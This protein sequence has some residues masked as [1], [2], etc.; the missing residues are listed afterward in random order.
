[1]K[2]NS[3]EEWF[4]PESKRLG[5]RKEGLIVELDRTPLSRHLIKKYDIKRKSTLNYHK[6]TQ[7]PQVCVPLELCDNK[8]YILSCLELTVQWMEL[9]LKTEAHRRSVTTQD[10]YIRNLVNYLLSTCQERD[11]ILSRLIKMGLS[12]S[13]R[14]DKIAKATE[15]D[16]INA[17]HQDASN[18]SIFK[19]LA[20]S[21]RLIEIMI[22]KN[23]S[24]LL[25]AS[26]IQ[27]DKQLVYKLMIECLK[28]PV[29][30]GEISGSKFSIPALGDELIKELIEER[31]KNIECMS[32][33][34]YTLLKR[35]SST[36]DL[37]LAKKAVA[38]NP[39][40]YSSLNEELK[41][42][43]EIL[44][45]LSNDSSCLTILG[46]YR[47]CLTKEEIMKYWGKGPVHKRHVYLYRN[48]LEFLKWL[49][50][51]HPDCIMFHPVDSSKNP[52]GVDELLDRGI[53]ISL[54]P[55][56][57]ESLLD[58]PK[59]S[60]ST[61]ERV[62][63]MALE[64]R[65]SLLNCL[66]PSRLKF[67][68]LFLT[69]LGKIKK[70]RMR[71]N[72]ESPIL[73][74]FMKALE[75]MSPLP[76]WDLSLI[77][78]FLEVFP[79]GIIAL[80]HHIKDR[81]RLLLLAKRNRSICRYM[82]MYVLSE[83]AALQ[84]NSNDNESDLSIELARILAPKMGLKYMMDLGLKCSVFF[85]QVKE[86][87]HDPSVPA[88]IRSMGPTNGQ[89]MARLYGILCQF[90]A[91]AVDR[92]SSSRFF[93]SIRF[94][95]PSPLVSLPLTESEF[96]GYLSRGGHLLNVSGYSI[97]IHEKMVAYRRQLCYPDHLPI[98][99]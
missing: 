40:E 36:P 72:P 10:L 19:H 33:E 66:E 98:N 63:I 24:E 14:S 93:H 7:Y 15:Q 54:L 52:V 20:K 57:L 88:T 85:A 45:I 80:S 77:S 34:R 89:M 68:T 75:S 46:A 12:H 26:A 92:E 99:H 37:D 49:S 55:T 51:R 73:S 41:G 69:C 62:V 53:D 91:D 43:V 21:E 59:L 90:E 79:G 61:R 16:A 38:V 6:D 74:F 94:I 30:L 11:M 97:D 13:I 4:K 31:Y 28:C 39:K 95:S 83:L 56:N 86:L 82:P 87:F 42:N 65:P 48:D 22:K 3:S 76:W 29:S 18:Y 23:Q 9:L 25:S 17:I 60:N 1:M 44:S 84:A 96:D 71:T 27:R 35:L 58:D 5:A 78:L 32:G 50:D 67:R 8:E 47:P 2:R 64:K 81:P 70:S